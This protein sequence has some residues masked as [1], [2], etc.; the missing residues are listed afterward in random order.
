MVFTEMIVLDLHVKFKQ[1]G[2]CVSPRCACLSPIEF[3]KILAEIFLF[4][5]SLSSVKFIL[6]FCSIAGMVN[7]SPPCSSK[8]KTPQVNDDRNPVDSRGNN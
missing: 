2:S 6:S 4:F 3:C 1:A 8:Y 5:T 7:S